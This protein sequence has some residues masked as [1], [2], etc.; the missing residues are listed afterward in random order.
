MP[1]RLS[2]VEFGAGASALKDVLRI[3]EHYDLLSFVATQKVISA[4]RNHPEAVLDR[5]HICPIRTE[6]P[7]L[8][9]CRRN[10]ELS[11]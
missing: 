9:Y 3:E 8:G 6:T 7:R 2:F 4:Q 5:L 10:E 1:P 11:R